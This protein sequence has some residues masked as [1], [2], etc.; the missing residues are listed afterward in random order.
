MKLSDA[1]IEILSYR[2]EI[3]NL[4]ECLEAAEKIVSL[5]RL[6]MESNQNDEWYFKDAIIAYD[7]AVEDFQG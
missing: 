2:T 7:K 4:R 3:K 1:D 6:T 5:V